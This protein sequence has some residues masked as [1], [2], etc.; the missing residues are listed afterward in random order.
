MMRAEPPLSNQEVWNESHPGLHHVQVSWLDMEAMR[1]NEFPRPQC[2]G[3]EGQGIAADHKLAMPGDLSSADGDDRDEGEGEPQA[4]QQDK[5]DAPRQQ[6]IRTN[7]EDHS[8][9]EIDHQNI[10]SIQTPDQPVPGPML[11]E[12][13]AG[14]LRE[15]GK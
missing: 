3:R 14:E 12:D 15:P 6:A 4:V 5:G 7:G 9:R 8:R 11:A 13:L 2:D 1:E 10:V